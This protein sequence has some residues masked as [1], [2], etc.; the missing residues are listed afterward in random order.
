MRTDFVSKIEFWGLARRPSLG[1]RSEAV[2]P[3][4]SG[5][6]AICPWPCSAA[7]PF[8]IVIDCDRT[9]AIHVPF[10]LA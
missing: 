2:S 7:A 6:Y 5:S 4:A 9:Q 1:W 3:F 10:M 8:H